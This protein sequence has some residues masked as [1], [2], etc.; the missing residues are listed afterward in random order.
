MASIRS[1]RKL[2]QRA[3]MLTA[4]R[5]LK[6]YLPITL[7]GVQAGRKNTERAKQYKK[8]KSHESRSELHEKVL[9]T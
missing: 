1:P 2:D 7:S 5:A 4:L 3:R 8:A 6:A 9:G